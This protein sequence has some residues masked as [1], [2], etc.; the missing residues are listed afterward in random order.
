MRF[1]AYSCSHFGGGREAVSVGM[2]SFQ[3]Q[4]MMQTEEFLAKITK[5]LDDIVVVA[6]C[7]AFSFSR[8]PQLERCR[9]T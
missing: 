7:S 6:T 3:L 1:T 2:F 4:P 9:L 8:L 5:I